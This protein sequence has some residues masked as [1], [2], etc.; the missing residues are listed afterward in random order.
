MTMMVIDVMMVM[1][2][3]MLLP[4]TNG[5][6][7]GRCIPA[8]F[9]RAD[10]RSLPLESRNAIAAARISP[11]RASRALMMFMVMLLHAG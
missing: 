2:M 11:I 9:L 8:I 5:T 4:K 1:V 7:D 6:L 3:A 10:K